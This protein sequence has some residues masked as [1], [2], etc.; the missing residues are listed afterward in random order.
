MDSRRDLRAVLWFVALAFGLTWLLWATLWLPGAAENRLHALLAATLGM[1]VPG[2]V[3]LFLT[4][5][6]LRES[7]RTMAIGRLGAIR[8]YLWAWLLP[9]AGTVASTGLTVLFGVASFDP[10]LAHAREMMEAT[11][12]PLPAPVATIVAAQLALS[13][14]LAPLFNVLFALGEELGWRAFL[15]PRLLG[16]GSSQ[17]GALLLSGAVWGL[18]HAPLIMLGHNYPDHPYIGVLLMTGFCVL[19]GVIFG[20]LRLASGSVW[21]PALAHGSLNA[22]A[23]TPLLLLTP[24]D[25][26]LGG[27]LTS[28]I[29]W[30]PMLAFIGWLI[31]S[32]R[33]P[34]ALK[35]Q[36]LTQDAV[37]TEAT[38]S[39][40]AR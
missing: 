39:A 14:T 4:R 33:L 18:W 12:K 1:W 21:V 9:V 13:L 19:L 6:Y 28:L 37:P 26:A 32:R 3:A 17:W 2:L 40:A 23:G 24:F 20:W 22:V 31:W 25:T 35:D 30:I 38:S 10:Q 34:V 27:M 29:G 5:R 8:Y 36:P 11:G 7:L 16:A 15:L